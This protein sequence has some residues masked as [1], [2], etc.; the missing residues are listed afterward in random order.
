[1]VWGRAYGRARVAAGVVQLIRWKH[2]PRSIKLESVTLTII[3]NVRIFGK[4]KKH[5]KQNH[6]YA[7]RS[8]TLKP[9]SQSYDS[10]TLATVTHNQHRVFAG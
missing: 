10:A 4:N 7:I 3:K 1:M 2:I 5:F 8:C 6:G 9:G